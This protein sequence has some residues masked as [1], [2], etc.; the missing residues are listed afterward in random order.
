[1]GFEREQVVVALRAAYNNPDRAVEYLLNP[2]AMPRLP[3][4][5]AH[6][7]SSP[8]RAGQQPPARPPSSA[9]S[10]GGSSAP[11]GEEGED[12]VFILC[13]YSG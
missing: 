11:E 4:G 8:T 10:T 6:P 1:M 12:G 2:G 7:P 3:T 13:V 9:P 5:P